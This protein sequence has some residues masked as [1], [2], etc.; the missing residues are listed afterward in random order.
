MSN[1]KGLLYK[2]SLPFEAIVWALCNA[3]GRRGSAFGFL[4]LFIFALSPVIWIMT[5]SETKFR[6]FFGAATA[7]VVLLGIAK[8]KVTKNP[9]AGLGVGFIWKL[10]LALP[11]L[12]IFWFLTVQWAGD[13]FG[14]GPNGEP[15]K[16][17]II[18]TVIF[19]WFWGGSAL[20]SLARHAGTSSSKTPAHKRDQN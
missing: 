8:L 10:I 9:L 2:L 12:A 18:A 20:A 19:L 17:E 3:V 1:D 11:L 4:V 14:R 16:G 6:Y 7:I 13:R 5:G 15:G